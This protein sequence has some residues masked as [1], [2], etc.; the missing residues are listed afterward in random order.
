MIHHP[1]APP[2]VTQ[3]YNGGRSQFRGS[4]IVPY[5]PEQDAKK[6]E[7]ASELQNSP[8]LSRQIGQEVRKIKGVAQIMQGV[9]HRG[10][11]AAIEAR[12][13]KRTQ[14]R[15]SGQVNRRPGARAVAKA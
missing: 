7:R 9:H 1:R 15:A 8:Q 11:K 6:D 14:A 2:N 5:E 3:N 4:W 12:E 10:T 13:E